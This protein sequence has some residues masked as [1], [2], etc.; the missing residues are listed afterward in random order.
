MTRLERYTVDRYYK[1][2]GSENSAKSPLILLIHGAGGDSQHF[3]TVIP[4]LVSNGYRVLVLDVRFHGA[5]QLLNGSLDSDTITFSFD[6]VLSDIE[7]TLEE[8]KRV[9]YPEEKYVHLFIGGLSMG[10]MVSLLYATDSCLNK[11]LAGNLGIV[12]EGIILIAAG[13]PHMHIPRIGWD[14]YS[15]RKA[16]AEYLEWTRS[17][18]IQSALTEYGQ[19]E[20]TRAM[21]LISDHNLFECMVAIAT[22]LPSPSSAQPNSYELKTKKPMLLLIPDKDPYIRPEMELLHQI[23]L[24]NGVNSELVTVYDSGHMAILDKGEEVGTLILNFC[25]KVRANRLK[26]QDD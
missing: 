18:I 4:N 3:N 10:G 6:D 14:I 22:L 1:V 17:A 19:K 25:N 24:E 15:E 23:N 5:S 8:V 21:K 20:T 26:T 13:I 7:L 2:F 11:R 9:H 12:L 16:T